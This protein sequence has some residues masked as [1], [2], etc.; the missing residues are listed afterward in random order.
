MDKNPKH[1]HGLQENRM[2]DDDGFDLPHLDPPQ[3]GDVKEE[4]KIGNVF[5]IKG[6]LYEIASYGKPYSDGSRQ[7]TVRLVRRPF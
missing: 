3:L 6:S 4:M 5:F 1:E 2:Q 7:A